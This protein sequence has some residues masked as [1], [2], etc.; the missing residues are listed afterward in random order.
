MQLPLSVKQNNL[1]I[2]IVTVSKCIFSACETDF[3]GLF[4]TSRAAMLVK[5]AFPTMPGL[6]IRR[7]LRSPG[8]PRVPTDILQDSTG[9]RHSLPL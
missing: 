2:Q 4:L 5:Q 1:R 6:K 9:Q 8:V 3:E 7:V